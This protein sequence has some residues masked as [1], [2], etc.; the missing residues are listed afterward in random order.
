MKERCTYT[1]DKSFKYYGG[2]G[3]KVEWQNLEDFKRDMLVSYEKHLKRHGEKNTTIDRIDNNK[4]YCKE[5]CRWATKKQQ[6]ANQSPRQKIKI[7][8][9]G[10][11]KTL[12]E[13][14]KIHEIKPATYRYRKVILKLSTEEAFE[15]P[16]GLAK[17]TR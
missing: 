13:W 15:T 7:E 3:I 4:N 11:L 12:E 6:I 5:N 8:Y 16:V 2:K 1:K 17:K 10:Q 14:C 9:A